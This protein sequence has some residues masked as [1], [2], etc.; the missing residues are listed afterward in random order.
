MLKLKRFVPAVLISGI[1]LMAAA[2]AQAS[3]VINFTGGY[4]VGNW[5]STIGGDGL[6]DVTGAP[7]S[8]TLTGSND[9]SGQQFVDFTIAALASGTV[10]FFWDYTSSDITSPTWD[11]FG[12]LL[13]NVFTRLTVN[14]GSDGGLNSQSG[15]VSFGV[16]SGDIFGFRQASLDSTFGAAFTTISRFS[17]P[18]STVPEPASIALIGLGLVGLRLMRR[19]RI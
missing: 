18:G 7:T 10:S 14:G 12:Y 17:A 8:V 11:P 1:A 4:Q 2:T 5:T 19:R 6:I 15:T 16:L 13:N 9:K 3:P